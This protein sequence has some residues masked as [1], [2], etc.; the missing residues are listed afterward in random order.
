M[1]R[2][3]SRSIS[4]ATGLRNTS[5][6]TVPVLWATYLHFIPI[7]EAV[8]GADAYD[9]VVYALQHEDGGVLP[10]Q[11]HQGHVAHLLLQQLA[12]Q[13]DALA[14]VDGHLQ[15]LEYGV[16]VRVAVAALVH[17][18]PAVRVGSDDFGVGALCVPAIRGQVAGQR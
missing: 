18:A 13:V 11:G 4:M 2:R 3:A 9:G 14:R 7:L 5:R 10:V 17:A 15:P 16:D 1:R 8:A 6:P 12:V